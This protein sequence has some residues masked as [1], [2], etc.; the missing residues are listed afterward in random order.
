MNKNLSFR[1][2]AMSAIMLLISACS[3]S[4]KT[5]YTNAIPANATEVASINLQA[6]VQKSGLNDAD[7]QAAKQKLLAAIMDGTTPAIGKQL[8]SI[9]KDP[10]ETG[11]DWSAPVYVFHAPS[12]HGVAMAIKVAD[13]KK[14]KSLL[15]TLEKENLCT[16]PQ[17]NGNYQTVDV[18]EG[19]IQLAFND[20][21]LLVIGGNT[22]QLKK[23]SPAITEL[24]KQSADKSIHSN[25]YFEQLTT[26]KGDINFLASPTSLPS[27]VRGIMTW[28]QG[29]Q[30]LGNV[31][32]ENGSIKVTL[33]QA[34]FEG[35]TTESDQPSHPK[36]LMELQQT[37]LTIMKGTPF[38][39]ELTSDELMTITN[40]RVL[41]E[42]APDEPQVQMLSQVINQ[43]ETI[44]AR[45]DNNRTTLI[46]NLKD[47]NNNAL[48]QIIDFAKQFAGL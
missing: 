47:K 12:L 31:Q 4:D 25:K 33:Q 43:I 18:K 24:M 23:L 29:A 2:L 26:Q 42:Y 20:G 11:I 17:K 27:E 36:S 5:E 39:I 35:K 32:F 15:G 9:V 3:S 34:G 8:E 16:S 7:N 13:L 10:S 21:T 19:N 30:L 1:L 22:E 40:L 48:K 44:A 46:V 28:P 38:N 37:M 45:G 6:L 41:M 14:L